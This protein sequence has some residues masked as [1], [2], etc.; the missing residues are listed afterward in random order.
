MQI[1]ATQLVILALRKLYEADRANVY[2]NP[3]DLAFVIKAR[4]P[5]Y[6]GIYFTF[7]PCLHRD[8]SVAVLKAYGR[9][10]AD[11]RVINDGATLAPDWPAGVRQG[12]GI[13]DP[14]YLEMDAIADAWKDE[15]YEPG[16]AFAR[17]WIT[18]LTAGDSPTWTAAD[19]RQLMDAI[20]GDTLRKAKA[21]RW[22]VRLY[23]TGV[24]L[25]G[26]LAHHSSGI[27]AAVAL[28]LAV[29]GCTGGCMSPP[30]IVDFPDGPPEI[31]QVAGKGLSGAAQ[32]FIQEAVH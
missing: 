3:R 8:E 9:T 16:P 21:R 28:A 4:L 31:D 30:D 27:A 20:F 1:Q 22:I 11:G 32:Q 23:Y 18:R 13:H 5:A 15:P 2:V 25:A 19:V 10:N 6:D 24:R 26:R 7:S 14:G 29:S 17:D 12:A